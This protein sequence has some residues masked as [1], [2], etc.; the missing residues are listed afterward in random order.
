MKRSVADAE[1]VA[2]VAEPVVSKRMSKKKA[3]VD[4]VSEPV[5]K[6]GAAKTKAPKKTSKDDADVSF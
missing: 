2:A 6:K 3:K 5:P 4:A 1:A